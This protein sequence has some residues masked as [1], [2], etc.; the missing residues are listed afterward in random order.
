MS[1]ILINLFSRKDVML[2]ERKPVFSLRSAASLIESEGVEG[3][4]LQQQVNNHLHRLRKGDT[5]SLDEFEQLVD[6]LLNKTLEKARQ[7]TLRQ[8]HGKLTMLESFIK[9]FLNDVVYDELPEDDR[10]EIRERLENKLDEIVTE[11]HDEKRNAKRVLKFRMP[12]YTLF[13]RLVRS[14][15]G[16]YQE[17]ARSAEEEKLLEKQ[18]QSVWERLHEIRGSGSHLTDTVDTEHVVE[19]LEQFIEVVYDEF[20]H[21][22]QVNEDLEILEV[23]LVNELDAIIKDMDDDTAAQRIQDIKNEVQRHFKRD[24]KAEQRIEDEAKQVKNEL[25]DHDM[26]TSS[27]QTIPS[28]LEDVIERIE[29]VYYKLHDVIEDGQQERRKLRRIAELLEELTQYSEIPQESETI[30]E[31]ENSAS[32]LE[33]Q[34]YNEYQD[35]G[36]VRRCLHTME[37]QLQ[38]TLSELK[39]MS[40]QLPKRKY[41]KNEE[42]LERLQL[43]PRRYPVLADLALETADHMKQ[44][45]EEDEKHDRII[46]HVWEPLTYFKHLFTDDLTHADTERIREDVQEKREAKSRTDYALALEDKGDVRERLRSERKLINQQ[47]REAFTVCFELVYHVMR[48]TVTGE[49]RSD[50]MYEVL[51]YLARIVRGTKEIA[52]LKKL[53]RNDSGSMKGFMKEYQDLFEQEICNFADTVD[54]VRRINDAV[55]GHNSFVYQFLYRNTQYINSCDEMLDAAQRYA[56]MYQSLEP[57]PGDKPGS[58]QK[59]AAD[60]EELIVTRQDFTSYFELMKYLQNGILVSAIMS[61]FTERNITVSDLL[62]DHRDLV[63]QLRRQTQRIDTERQ[64]TFV[65][66]LSWFD[67]LLHEIDDIHHVFYLFEHMSEI[68]GEE[69]RTTLQER[70]QQYHN[71][72]EVKKR[73]EAG[74]DPS[75]IVLLHRVLHFLIKVNDVFNDLEEAAAYAKQHTIDKVEY[76]RGQTVELL[77]VNGDGHERLYYVKAVTV[78][79]LMLGHVYTD[80]VTVVQPDKVEKW[81]ETNQRFFSVQG[82]REMGFLTCHVTDAYAGGTASDEERDKPI[83]NIRTCL[84]QEGEF[85]LS[86]STIH[87]EY[88]GEL[89]KTEQFG[90]GCIGVVLYRGYVVQAYHKDAGSFSS[91]DDTYRYSVVRRPIPIRAAVAQ[92]R[93]K[94][95]SSRLENEYTYNELILRN[96]TV[97]GLFYSHDAETKNKLQVKEIAEEHDLPLYVINGNEWEKQ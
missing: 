69:E 4:E 86:A 37:E 20:T 56:E 22:M 28:S 59:H 46:K 78:F 24:Y 10:D 16:L 49:S 36:R 97:E 57:V 21:M 66:H 47:N 43:D 94:S 74:W 82:L 27:Q 93:E 81:S 2:E 61:F 63:E 13:R 31:L 35:S 52:C 3:E 14:Q 23:D 64:A 38:S 34:L 5:S 71:G 87:P 68:V 76:K 80:K 30:Q 83:G 44:T 19:E 91:D 39:E 96:W 79:G 90:D 25:P 9:Q 26:D 58:L 40:E 89:V 42:L 1:E 92:D 29:K 73:K 48:D 6:K 60:I 53:F 70:W 54:E 72:E 50:A 33:T 8:E 18:E 11:L 85:P 15:K 67:T 51:P 45:I 95:G 7:Y 65:G 12:A 75:S 77:T 17:V 41:Q 32:T 62:T 84:A 55:A 88:K